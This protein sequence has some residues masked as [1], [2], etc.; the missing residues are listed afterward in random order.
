[1]CRIALYIQCTR[2]YKKSSTQSQVFIAEPNFWPQIVINQSMSL[3]I[4]DFYFMFQITESFKVKQY[5]SNFISFILT[6]DPYHRL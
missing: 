3:F 1:M 5:A 4:L 2:F 6:L